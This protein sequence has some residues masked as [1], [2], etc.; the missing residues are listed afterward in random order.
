MKNVLFL[1]NSLGGGGAERVCVN[2][3]NYMAKNDCRVKI[4]TV[5]EQT[6]VTGYA[7]H[8]NIEVINLGYNLDSKI[9][10]IK[11]LLFAHHRINHYL[12][13]TSLTWDL[14]TSHLPMSNIIT[15]RS[16]IGKKAIYV[17]HSTMRTFSKNQSAIFKLGL[18]AFFRKRKVCCVSEGIR[19]ECLEVYGF[20]KKYTFTIYNPLDPEANSTNVDNKMITSLKP[21][22]LV[23]GRLNVLKR[24]DRAIQIFEQGHFSNSLNLVFCGDGELKDELV[25]QSQKTN[26]SDHIHF[27]GWQ[28]DVRSWIKQAEVLLCTS[29]TEGFPMNLVE[30]AR[31]GVKIVSADCQFG[32]N[33][34]LTGEYAKFLV[35]DK[36][37]IASYISAI[38]QALS[39]YPTAKNPIIEQ[40][41]PEIIVNQYFKM[42]QKGKK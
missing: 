22:I 28:D 14:I 12:K 17:F 36:T 29:D 4:I 37:D 10:K 26:C 15:R 7:L 38:K 13:H 24:Q 19:K 23:V 6:K 32:P 34:I 42:Y 18:R 16:K 27:V 41:S 21:Y 20:S 2:L 5:F 30:G 25:Q 11:C 39:K 31:E 35:K 9:E 1:V 3:A 40:C 33:E 8:S